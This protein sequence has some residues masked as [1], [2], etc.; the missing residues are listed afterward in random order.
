MDFDSEIIVR[1][2]WSGAALSQIST[3]V[4]YP[5]NGRSSFR[6]WEDNVLITKMHT[7]LFF[8]MLLRFPKLIKRHFSNG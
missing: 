3:R 7:R 2:Y 5:E 1:W 8:G 4:I 6:L